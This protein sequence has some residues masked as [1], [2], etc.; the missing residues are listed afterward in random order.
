MNDDDL[1]IEEVEVT[2]EETAA[3]ESMFQKFQNW[4]NKG[5][6]KPAKIEMA[7]KKLK[8]AGF[9]VDTEKLA[10]FLDSMNG[11]EE[12]DEESKKGTNPGKDNEMQKSDTAVV[13]AVVKAQLEMLQ[14]GWQRERQE[15]EKAA[16]EKYA[17]QIADLQARVEKAE[18]EK[19][20]E[21]EARQKREFVEKAMEFR[22]TPISPLEM[23]DLLYKAH[24]GLPA[25]AY[26][27]LLAVLKSQDNL[28]GANAL[29]TEWGHNRTVEEV[30]LDEKAQAVAK[31]SNIPYG[32]ALLQ[33]SETE[34]LQLLKEMRGGN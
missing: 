24:K 29:F 27:E 28:L 10:S 5:K 34:Q 18:L 15:I 7:Q 31:A 4:L 6:T 9:M 12:D 25:E 16:N 8:E 21:T 11:D 26:E 22:A 30:A 23:G 1:V 20:A 13:E 14:A 19:A 33:L 2:H 3:D 17:G 32:E